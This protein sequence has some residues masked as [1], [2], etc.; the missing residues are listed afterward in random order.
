MVGGNA[1]NGASR[2]DVFIE[3]FRQGRVGG[4]FHPRAVGVW[5]GIH[6]SQ[7]GIYR[8]SKGTKARIS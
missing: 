6:W 3:G 4:D 5:E 2:S 8:S 1:K 7:K